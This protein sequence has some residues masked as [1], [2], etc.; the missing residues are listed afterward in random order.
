MA[1]SDGAAA[2]VPDKYANFKLPDVG[3]SFEEKQ[4]EA[5]RVLTDLYTTFAPS[6]LPDIPSLLEAY[7][8]PPSAGAATDPLA[9]A[10]LALRGA[11]AAAAAAAA[12]GGA[13]G[14]AA[15]IDSSLVIIDNFKAVIVAQ[16]EGHL[17]EQLLK[18]RA[19]RVFNNFTCQNCEKE[20]P[21]AGLVAFRREVFPGLEM[22]AGD[23]D[24]SGGRSKASAKRRAVKEEGVKLSHKQQRYTKSTW[25]KE[26]YER[27]KI[28]SKEIDINQR[29]I[30]N[31]GGGGAASSGQG[32]GKAKA[33]T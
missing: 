31:D 6:K 27:G 32:K 17:R 26:S 15:S 13:G 24:I 19:E 5:R 22:M 10:L 16:D 20:A 25:R 11:A 4:E 33:E 28:D 18:E 8:G 23:A 29:S 21:W 1:A 14:E 2:N 30:K 12:S 7:A 3:R 9:S